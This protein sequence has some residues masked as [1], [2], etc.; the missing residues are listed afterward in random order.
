MRPADLFD[1]AWQVVRGNRG[2]TLLI[3]LAMGI[4]VAAVLVVTALGEGARRYVLQQFSGLGAN[5]LIVLPGRAET[6]GGIPGFLVGKTPRMLT[7]DDAQALTRSHGV[8]KVAP[9]IVGTGDVHVNA[10]SRET[11]VLGSTAEFISVRQMD[12][13]QGK[14]LPEGDPH[15]AQ[16]VCV[17]GAKIKSEL[18][19]GQAA[20]GEWL[21]IGDRRFRVVGVLAGQGQSL[22]F[23][24]D[25]IVIVPVAAAQALF[26]SEALFRV[27]V[28]AKSRAQVADAKADVLEILRQ[29]HEGERDVTVLTQD[30]VLS[31]FD[32][33]LG[34]LTLAVGGIAAISLSVAGI[35][36]MNVMLISVTQRK[37]EIGLLKALGATGR[38]IRLLFVTEAVLLAL[39]GAGA[40][41]AVGRLGEWVMAELY[42]AIPVAAPWWALVAAPLTALVTAILF[43]VAPARKAAR[44]DPVLALSSR[45]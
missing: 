32:R 34:A 15:H 8:R 26:N 5:L 39:G 10:R 7:L 11:A 33:I 37:R 18:F 30:A 24:T 14:F 44:L 31:T 9:L 4:G 21:R 13:A 29:R 3:L 40:G 22:G 23:N 19:G 41:L 43:S 1:F 2:R 35:L 36:I 42:P 28:E 27:L 45:R 38:Q 6:A 20:V 17:I 12:M 25:E 16:P